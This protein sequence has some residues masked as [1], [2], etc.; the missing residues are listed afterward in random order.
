MHIGILVLVVFLLSWTL[1]PP[2]P[3]QGGQ[4]IEPA[5]GPEE[6]D[7]AFPAKPLF[8][9]LLAYYKEPRFFMSYLATR[10]RSPEI[11]ETTIGSVGYGD[12]LPL[13]ERRNTGNGDGLQVGFGGGVF[14]QFDLE[15]ASDS[16][17]NADYTVG[18]P[19]M[20]RKGEVSGR[21]TFYHQSSHLGDELLLSGES[22]SRI[23]LSYDALQLIVARALN[24]WRPYLGYEYLVHKKPK[25]LDA[26]MVHAGCEF[27]GVRPLL[28]TGTLVAGLHLISM[29]EHDWEVDANLRLGLY[30][31]GNSGNG[32]QLLLEGYRGYAPYG[33]FYSYKFSYVGLG[34]F[35]DM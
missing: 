7:I 11:R 32:M 3:V 18:I 13:Y 16:L 19:M 25:D 15:T 33:Q 9:P 10:L 30:F 12:V 14:A 2:L 27:R 5:V 1:F 31:K 8:C 35:F 29:E 23:N 17:I 6:V 34:L 4:C 26:N 24:K 28:G 22:P 21:F 20:L